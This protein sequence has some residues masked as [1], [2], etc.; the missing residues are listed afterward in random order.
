MEDKNFF[1]VNHVIDMDE[2]ASYSLVDGNLNNNATVVIKD[3]EI[4]V[5]FEDESEEKKFR[6]DYE[7]LLDFVNS[8]QWNFIKLMNGNHRWRT[9]NPNPK[10]HNTG[11]CSLRAYCAAFGKT[12]EEAYD[13]ASK[14]AKENGYIMDATQACDKILKEGFNC[15]VD[16]T[17]N[18]KTV[19]SK[20]RITI[21]AFAMSHPYGTYIVHTHGHLTT[22]KNGEYWDS[23]DSGDKKIDVVYN[24]PKK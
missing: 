21:N 9:Y 13:I 12:W 14:I 22:V 6:D 11:D 8:K 10:S 24:L 3:G 2:D 4:T 19:K 5:Y 23:W 15:E 7:S 16:P 20:D 17:Y 18:R 1:I